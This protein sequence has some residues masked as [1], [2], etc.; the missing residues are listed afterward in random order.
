MRLLAGLAVVAA[1]SAPAAHAQTNPRFNVSLSIDYAAAE[2][3]VRLLGDESVNT[4]ALA[5]MRG[6]RIAAS[7]TGLIANRGSVSGVL[8][9]YLDSLKYHE[10]IRDDVYRLEGARRNIA[11]IAELLKELS[12]RNFSS[13]VVSTVEQIFPADA[14]VN[15]TIPVYVVAIGHDNVDAYVRRIV[16]RGDTPEFVG[17]GK[18]ELT[19]VI[20]LARSVEYGRDV[21][22]RL[23]N[24]LGVV[25]HEVFHAAFGA[26]K[27]QSPSWQ[28]YERSHRSPFHMLVDLVQNE[29]IAYYLSLEQSNQGNV[30]RDWVRRT[31]ETFAL[32]TKRAE[33]LL[34]RSLTPD[35]ASAI[36]REANLSGYWESF[37][38]MTGMF[39][40]REIDGQMGRAAL[41]ETVDLGPIDMLRKYDALTRRDTNLPELSPLLRDAL[42]LK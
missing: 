16:W 28:A 13:R 11:P 27:D 36:L 2:E 12:R 39:I 10:I 1:F 35:R 25:A 33:E 26:Y 42:E 8:A 34:S 19:I 29:G 40:A 22:E 38:S 20:N 23:V 18:G 32:F 24:L 15:I 6:N 37:G 4:Q 21:D 30:P 3:T 5:D 9:S 41:I 14:I 7:T 17:E 31:R